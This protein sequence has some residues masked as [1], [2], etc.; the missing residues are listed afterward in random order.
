MHLL[1]ETEENEGHSQPGEYLEEVNTSNKPLG[2]TL[3]LGPG[4]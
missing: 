4:F 3:Y 2:S 1:G